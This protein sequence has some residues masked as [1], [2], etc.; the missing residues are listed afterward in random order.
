MLELDPVVAPLTGD[1]ALNLGATVNAWVPP[2][3]GT[4]YLTVDGV[5][6]LDP[7]TTGYSDYGSR[8][9]YTV[10]FNVDA[11]GPTGVTA[12]APATQPNTVTVQW[13]PPSPQ[14]G[15]LYYRIKLFPQGG[16]SP[17]IVWATAPSSSRVIYWVPAGTYTAT[18]ESYS[19][20]GLSVPSPGSAPVTVFGIASAPTNV[21]ATGSP[22]TVTVSWTA[23]TETGGAPVDF[24]RIV[25]TPS[26]PAFG[27]I[28]RYATGS[29]TSYAAT[30]I[31]SG[32][33]T[34][35]VSAIAGGLQGVPSSAALPVTVIG[36]AGEP[37]S[38]TATAL[39]AGSITVNWAV[40]FEDGGTPIQYY[41]VAAAS[42]SGGTS[43]AY[44]VAS[45]GSVTL[46]D[47]SADSYSVSVAAGNSVSLGPDSPPAQNV[48]VTG[49]GGS[50]PTLP[51]QPTLTE[52]VPG[53]YGQM[54]ISWTAPTFAGTGI[55]YYRIFVTPENGSPFWQWA[56]NTTTTSVYMPD[57][58]FSVSVQA[59][60]SA[61][62]GLASAPLTVGLTGIA[63][64][65]GNLVATVDPGATS[66]TATWSP[67]TSTGGATVSYYRAMLVPENGSAST[68]HWVAASSSTAVFYLPVTGSYRVVVE[69][70]TSNGF[71]VGTTRS[72]V[73]VVP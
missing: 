51:G 61:G 36:L 16:G 5:G 49:S 18:V 38:V 7:L 68:P 1:S 34:A 47:L 54:R 65:P 8:G 32:T 4:Y 45:A 55:S 15:I 31:P 14:T 17:R 72:G 30:S 22:A 53:A 44:A 28:V 35:T 3:A 6:A 13:V 29:V 21:A 57:G 25:L 60:N 52:A 39:T 59:Y 67:P 23:P 9:A 43:V 10:T 70:F 66:I 58:T 48:V 33:Y 27:A 50:T 56:G 37:T 71:G 42:A 63:G 26:S 24:Y 73:L 20:S 64:A 41:R 46:T 19:V 12:I 11:D 2:A 40:P 62:L 69:A